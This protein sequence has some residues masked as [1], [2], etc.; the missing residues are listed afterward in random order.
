MVK[1]TAL[2]QAGTTPSMSRRANPLDNAPMESFFHT[3]KTELAHHRAY[4]TRDEAKRN[5][6]A[7]VERFYN[8]QRLYSALDYRAPDQEEQQAANVV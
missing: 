3:L 2:G 8:R 1:Q 4:A 7:H 5:L 6:F